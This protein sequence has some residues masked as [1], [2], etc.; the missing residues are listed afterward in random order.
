MEA[1]VI[2]SYSPPSP[3][4]SCHKS[5]T[6]KSNSP[7]VALA[8]RT[9][10]RARHP[11]SSGALAGS[12]TTSVTTVAFVTAAAATTTTAQLPAPAQ[13][14]PPASPHRSPPKL[15]AHIR[16]NKYIQCLSASGR[17]VPVVNRSKM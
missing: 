15:N 9:I 7:S 12:G 10:T 4:K 2:G 16:H 1:T 14:V 6:K 8:H 17:P 3:I 11:E 13:C 5:L